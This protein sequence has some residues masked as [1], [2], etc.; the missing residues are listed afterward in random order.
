MANNKRSDVHRPGAIVPADYSYRFSYSLPGM[1]GDPG[2][3]M[4]QLAEVRVSKAIVF[5]NDG[6][7]G[8]C[9]ANF[10]HGDVWNHTSG[11]LV[12]LGQ[13]C[14]EKYALLAD[15]SD[16]L[17]ERDAIQRATAARIQAAVN[18]E[19]RGK[20]LAENPGLEDAFNTDHYIVKD[21][22][23]RFNG[24][25]PTLSPAQIGLVFKIQKQVEDEAQRASQPEE[26]KVPAPEGKFT[27]QG[28]VLATKTY[29]GAYGTVR[30]MLVKV[31]AV[32]GHWLAWSTIPRDLG[33]DDSG[34]YHPLKGCEIEFTGTFQT[35]NEPHFSLVKRPT[36][37]K[38]LTWNLT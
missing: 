31:S 19:L 1:N 35:G 30:K 28:T 23:N 16:W 11:D 3:N 37:A 10:R 8:V 26:A 33:R 20:I 36:K 12:H 2:V 24:S 29:D 14:A 15:R 18:V 27:V 9:G 17:A 21:I 38:V 32:G 13:E 22:F 7:C 25:Y 6:K 5:G 34:S 4:K